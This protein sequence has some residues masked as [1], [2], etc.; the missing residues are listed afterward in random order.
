MSVAELVH[1]LT[2][3]HALETIHKGGARRNM[4][5]SLAAVGVAPVKGNTS[6]TIALST[7]RLLPRSRNRLRKM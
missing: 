1:E 3:Q 4:K 5:T 6:P 7:A 2:V